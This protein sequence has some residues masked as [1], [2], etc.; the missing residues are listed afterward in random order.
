MVFNGKLTKYW[1]SREDTSSPM[2]SLE[3]FFNGNNWCV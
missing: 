1:L 2:A 3:D